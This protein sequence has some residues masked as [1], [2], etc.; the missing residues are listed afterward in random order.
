MF[1]C[2]PLLLFL[3]A[4]STTAMGN[5]ETYSAQ[6]T[7]AP[8]TLK[9][10]ILRDTADATT[11]TQGPP[12]E[13]VSVK[14]TPFP[15]FCCSYNTTKISDSLVK[16]SYVLNL[17]GFGNTD[18][19]PAHSSKTKDFSRCVPSLRN[20]I[21]EFF[22]SEDMT[23]HPEDQGAA[24]LEVV[25]SDIQR[26][27]HEGKRINGLPSQRK[28]APGWAAPSVAAAA[29]SEPTQWMDPRTPIPD[30]AT[31]QKGGSCS[32]Q[33]LL[34]SCQWDILNRIVIDMLKWRRRRKSFLVITRMHQDWKRMMDRL[35]APK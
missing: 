11:T 35:R 16:G 26:R 7:P 10:L 13:I 9:S 8:T 15:S 28:W 6:I 14:P 34:Q 29:G 33:Q 5:P 21:D 12:P 31:C 20:A 23:A 30:D 32:G 1:I 27:K 4:L 22:M 24:L 3:S 25:V 2:T 19:S 18:S 17:N